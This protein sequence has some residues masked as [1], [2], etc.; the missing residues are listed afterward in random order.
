MT[1]PAPDRTSITSFRGRVAA[2][3]ER[4]HPRDVVVLAVDGLPHRLAEQ[5]WPDAVTEP[6]TSVLPTTS[7]A[8]WLSSLTGLTPGEHGVPGVVFA[9][10]DG[11][12][13]L[14]NAF[15][16]QGDRLT[17]ADASVFGDAVGLGYRPLAVPA[18][19]DAY[20]CSWR[21]E[22]LRHAEVVPGHRFYTLGE[23]P[24]SPRDPATVVTDVGNAIGE[25]LGRPGPRFVWC[26]VELDR[27]VHH[28][29]YDEHT[30]AALDGLGELARRLT[31][32][33]TV[34]VAHSDH[35]LV[36]TRHDPDLQALLDELLA[37][38]GARMGGAGRVRWLYG[39][40]I[41]PLVRDLE[42]ALPPSIRVVDSD[43]L[44]PPGSLARSR[45]GPVSLVADGEMFLTD[46]AYTHD[47]GS[48]ADDELLTPFTVW[49]PEPTA[50]GGTR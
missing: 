49:E 43:E 31:D 14:I 29:G 36:P 19:L 33:G 4:V 11:S 22:L 48:D 37:R 46:P 27:H 38:H 30:L 39:P 32:G 5:C 13:A 41:H 17:T 18:D 7:S 8:A 25:A 47:H 9:D 45:V 1:A 26:F 15:A 24:Y 10:P 21:G 34:V 2:L 6:L 16:Y 12:D 40:A 3:L 50:A 28:H 35:G 44:F 42:R 23:S 20:P